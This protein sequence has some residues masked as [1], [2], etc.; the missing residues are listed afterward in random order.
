M[1]IITNPFS[2]PKGIQHQQIAEKAAQVHHTNKEIFPTNGNV[3]WVASSI[4][5]IVSGQVG[6]A[7]TKPINI[8]KTPS[9]QLQGNP[10][11]EPKVEKK[12]G[13]TPVRGKATRANTSVV[14]NQNQ[15]ED[16]QRRQ[17]CS[18][19]RKFSINGNLEQTK[20][21]FTRKSLTQDHNGGNIAT[22]T[23]HRN[24][25]KTIRYLKMWRLVKGVGF[26]Q[27]GGFPTVQKRGQRKEIV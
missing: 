6:V 18:S 7:G 13:R 14:S 26:I 2:V 9:T 12:R 15:S 25:G 10:I 23:K 4:N 5:S 1:G 17:L 27:E 21:V 16:Q 22:S 11:R 3:T 20:K 24:G 8:Q 19:L